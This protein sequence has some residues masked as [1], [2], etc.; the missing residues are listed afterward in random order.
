MWPL[1]I[2]LPLVVYGWDTKLFGV[3]ATAFIS[4]CVIEDFGWYVVNPEV[5]VKELNTDFASYYPRIKIGSIRIPTFY[6]VSIIISIA[7]WYFL[8]K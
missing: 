1:L 5:K 6:F 4:G 8:W 7:L 2:T 3:L